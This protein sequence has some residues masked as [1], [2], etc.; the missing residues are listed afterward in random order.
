MRRSGLLLFKFV[1][2]LFHVYYLAK[3]REQFCRNE[4]LTDE[5]PLRRRT[6]YY[7]LFRLRVEIDPANTRLYPMVHAWKICWDMLGKD[8]GMLGKYLIWCKLYAYCRCCNIRRRSI[9][10]D[11][12]DIYGLC[13]LFWCSLTMMALPMTLPA[14]FRGDMMIMELHPLSRAKRLS[15]RKKISDIWFLTFARF[16]ILS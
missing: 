6:Q 5:W 10:C 13:I 3:W 14:K 9:R 2:K 7:R 4:C 16:E 15:H 12:P 8:W 11:M 1:L